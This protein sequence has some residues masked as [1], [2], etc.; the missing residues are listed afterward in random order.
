MYIPEYAI[1][2]GILKNIASSE[3]AKAII[4]NTTILPMWE[5]QLVKE[6]S[7]LLLGSQLKDLGATLDDKTIKKALDDLA[8]PSAS[9]EI[10]SLI[11][12]LE[13]VNLISTA[14]D[15]EEEDI[16]QLYKTLTGNPP[17]YRSRYVEGKVIPEEIL[18]EIGELTDWYTS[19]D[20]KDT[21]PLIKAGILKA[22]LEKI[23]PFDAA[24]SVVANF[25]SLISVKIDK[26][27]FKGFICVE[28]YYQRYLADYTKSLVTVD[29]DLTAWLEFFV[30]AVASEAVN[31]KEKV[32]LLS[33]DTKIAKASGKVDISDRQA[34]II[35]YLQDYGLLQNKQFATIF[36]DISE[37]SVLRDLKDLMEKG[38]VVKRGK[39]KNSR[40]ELR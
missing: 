25:V 31:L 12:A 27:D 40:Y 7:V 14:S 5:K 10:L 30:R 20:A 39:T 11:N 17:V 4:D 32:L 1:T 13:L 35:E 18:A 26:Y 8:Q 21:H 23:A 34:R 22:T 2:G 37:D 15:I 29:D 38:V 24:N 19:L 16:K 6:A 3:Y 28:N 33:R 9:K 36:P